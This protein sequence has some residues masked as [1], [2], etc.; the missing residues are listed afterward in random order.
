MAVK[1]LTNLD[2]NGNQLLNARLQVLAS[3]PG[4]AVAGDIIYNSSTNVFKFYNGTDWIDPSLGGISG[5]G[6]VGTVPVFVTNT[7]TIGDSPITISGTRADFSGGIRLS[8]GNID[9]STVA[10]TFLAVN[11]GLLDKDL[12]IGTAGQLLSST[13]TQ[14]NWINAPV[15]Y[16]KWIAKSSTTEDVE[17]GDS[18]Q[19][20]ESASRPGI[21]IPPVTKASTIVT[22]P[23][24]LWTK[25]M[26]PASPSSFNTDVLLWSTNT[27]PW[28]VKKTDID[29]IPV[30]AWGQA[31]ATV[32]M[33]DNL[34][35]K[36]LDPVSAQDAATKA[37]VDSS[38][39]GGL[40]V[41]GGFNASTGITAVAGTNL[42]T[43][44][45][46]A[47]G[48]YYTVTA[49]G[50]FFGQT[51]TPLTP[52]DSVLVQTAAASGSATITD[53][54]VIQ[55]DTD[56]AT[57]ATIGI[58]NVNPDS[59]ANGRGLEVN[60]VNG[61]ATVSLNIKSAFP[62]LPQ[63]V[64]GADKLIIWDGT[65]GG[66]GN[67][68]IEASTLNSGFNKANT[69]YGTTTNQTTHIFNHNLGTTAIIV[70]LWDGASQQVVYATTEYTSINQVIV[71][72]S[73]SASLS[74]AVQK[75][76]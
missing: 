46:I 35:I 48:D 59:A 3:D 68:E 74:C 41:K 73:S 1:F 56:L 11:Q 4:T 14:V 45:A 23:L 72:T 57:L 21:F 47:I 42:Y 51:S 52:G 24:A 50:N 20:A 26:T 13:G 71:S 70:Q 28:D 69:F 44:T 5:S 63:A 75:M 66:Q 60:Y 16:T 36:V 7:T 32:D 58:G 55:S 43:N 64:G 38:V 9:T 30:S 53:F 40:N 18:Y 61:T 25:N 29:D 31:G 10:G 19:L 2:L 76:Q 62:A 67:Y 8:G 33:G 65:S 15:S 54:A 6:T 17:D 37:Y 22:Q 27:S 49:A 12:D 39:A 34:I